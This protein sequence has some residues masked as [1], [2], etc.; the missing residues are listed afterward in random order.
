MDFS[1]AGDRSALNPKSVKSHIRLQ[2]S[3][4]TNKLLDE[5]APETELP[6]GRK[7]NRT[8]GTRE[9]DTERATSFRPNIQKS[10]ENTKTM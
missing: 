10:E 1:L 7:P 6:E 2:K 5:E 9:P 3:C 8:L 4:F